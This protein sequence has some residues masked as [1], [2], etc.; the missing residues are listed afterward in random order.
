MKPT[1]KL[2]NR[3]FDIFIPATENRPAIKATTI[4]V[5]VRLDED[6]DEI[7]TPESLELVE[8]T[9]A[10][11]MGLLTGSDIRTLRERLK[12]SQGELSELLGCGDKSLS[13]WE[14]G[15]GYP[16]QLVNTILRALDEGLLT[17]SQLRRLQQPRIDWAGMIYSSTTQGAHFQMNRTP[18]N[19]WADC[20]A[21]KRGNIDTHCLLGSS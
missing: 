17:P 20:P 6:G 1:A 12:L 9:Q 11:Y 8:K 2:Q 4:T 7:L 3:S 21:V 14:N 13:R 19:T 5:Q 10:R 16:S 18:S 15:H